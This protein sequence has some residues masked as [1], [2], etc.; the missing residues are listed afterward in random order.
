MTNLAESPKAGYGSKVAVLPMMMM[1]MV[2]V[3]IMMI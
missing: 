3:M 1:M 2:M